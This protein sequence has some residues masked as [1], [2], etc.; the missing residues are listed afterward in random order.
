MNK[1]SR[2]RFLLTFGLIFL[3]GFYWSY[4]QTPNAWI[5]EMHYDNHGGDEDEMIEVV[6]EE[7][8]NWDLSLLRVDFYNGNGGSSYK[9]NTIDSYNVGEEHGSFS[10][11]SCLISG[12][13]NGAPDG[14]ALSYDGTVI[15]FLSYEGVFTATDGPASGQTSTD[16]GVFEDGSDSL[17]ESLQLAGTGYIYS[18]FAWQESSKSTLGKINIAQI[19]G[20]DTIPPVALWNPVNGATDVSITTNLVISFDE[21][22]RDITTDAFFDNT[23]IDAL[24]TFNQT[25]E[26][27]ESVS[28][29]ATIENNQVITITPDAELLNSQL[30]FIAVGEVEDTSDNAS[31]TE[32]ITFTTIAPKDEP[33]NHVT[34]FVAT[35][36]THNAIKLHWQDAAAGSQLPDGYL[37]KA[38]NT[39]I[40][41][42]SDAVDPFEDENLSDG[43]A[44]V[45]VPHG[46]DTT[47]IFE[48]LAPEM[49]YKFKI[50][51]YTN[52]GLTIDFKLDGEV[53]EVN[54]STKNTELF[55]S[56]YIKGSSNN[57]ALEIYNGTGVDVDLSD[58]ILR[59]YFNGSN[60]SGSSIEL[61]GTLAHGDVYV[62]SNG[63]ADDSTIIAETD[64]TSGVTNFNGDD[65]IEL[66]KK[67][68]SIDIIGVTGNDPGTSWE[69]AGIS[70]ATSDHTLIRKSAKAYGNTDWPVSAGTAKENSE[71]IVMPLDYTKNLGDYRAINSDTTLAD[72]TINGKTI[73]GFEP[74]KFTYTVELPFGTMD[75]PTVSAT[76]ND[77]YATVEI[78]QAQNLTGTES[79]RT[80]IV[81]VTADNLCTQDYIVVFSIAKNTANDITGFVFE[82]FEPN[83]IGEIN[84]KDYTVNIEVPYGINVTHLTPTIDIS[85]SATIS[86]QSGVA[87]NFTNPVIYTVTAA[88]SSEQDWIVTVNEGLNTENDILTFVFEDLNP[89]VEGLIDNEQSNVTLTVPYG[90]KVTSLKPTIHISPEAVVSP[91]SGVEQDFT[92][93][94]HYTI[95]AE[96]SSEQIWEVS[97]N[98]ADPSND[99]NLAD[100]KVD[101]FS[102]VDFSETTYNYSIELPYNST[103]TPIITVKK[104]DINAHAVV[105]NAKDVTSETEADRTTTV[106]VTAEDGSTT[107]KY[108]ILFNVSDA[109]SDASLSDLRINGTTKEGFSGLVLEYYDTIDVRPAV[110][111]IVSAKANVSD[112]NINVVNAVNLYGTEEERTTTITVTAED[113]I[114]QKIYTVKFYVKS[115]DATVK[116]LIIDG[117][118]VDSFEPA[119]LQYNIL[120]P[121]GT[122]NAP[123]V[124]AVANNDKALVDISQATESGGDEAVKT[125]F[126]KVTA[127]DEITTLTYQIIFTVADKKDL[128]FSEYIEGESYN[129][130]IELYN[131][132][133]HD[134]DLAPYTVKLASNGEG[135]GLTYNLSDTLASKRAYVIGNSGAS[136]EILA[137]ADTTSGVVNFNGNDALGLFKNDTLIDRIGISTEDKIWDVA[138]VTEATINNTLLRKYSIN[139]GCVNWITSAGTDS[140]NSEWIVWKQDSISNLGI[141]TTANNDATLSE[142]TINGLIVEGFSPF[143][144]QYEVELPFGSVNLPLID[145]ITTDTNATAIIKQIINLDYE[146]EQLAVVKVTAENGFASETY[147]IAFSIAKPS[148]DAFIFSEKYVVEN[149]ENVIS[150]IPFGTLLD[151]LKNNITPSANASFKVYESDGET[152]ATDL[153]SG[154]KVV[155]VAEDKIT[156]NI[157]TISINEPNNEATLSSEDFLIDNI[158]YTITRVPLGTKLTDFENRLITASG[159]SFE[160]FEADGITVADDLK[161][162]Y[163]VI[164][165]AQDEVTINFYTVTVNES[166]R[167]LFFSEYIEGTSDNKALEIYNPTFKTVDLS[168]YFLKGTANAATDW[169][170]NYQFP[171]GASIAS[172]QVYV[173]VNS[174]AHQSMLDSADWVV[175]GLCTGFN[176]N[177]TRGLFK[178]IEEDTTLI[179]VIGNFDNPEGVGYNV[180]GIEDALSDHTLI[181]KSSITVGNKNWISSAG[182]S[183]DSSEWLVFEKDFLDNLGVH[184]IRLSSEAEIIEFTFGQAVAY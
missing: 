108:T 118:L 114:N 44:I 67:D 66:V 74:G 72:L 18:D 8:G 178:I 116:E 130:A 158:D 126:I 127:E 3:T 136:A 34:D 113:N 69:V 144:Y 146:N 128:F 22:I 29:D 78:T 68:V 2:I 179:D 151:T 100:I 115:C 83:I 90:T 1:H 98:V 99:A 7:A 38:S 35:A 157:Y 110:V 91:K 71:W 76:A 125:A 65:V 53:P 50:W 42:P 152:I 15:Q 41:P 54:E 85:D 12:I 62:I 39:S 31:N 124:E 168:N 40:I 155:V 109:E 129:K 47:Y 49:S 61:S 5:N 11:F 153:M 25:D 81:T 156:T 59:L 169:E 174:N 28:F 20:T 75:I 138:G 14:V 26:H 52:E 180:A 161:T 122:A 120:L 181:R 80:A 21:P 58:Y 175:N 123:L 87:Q 23:T 48:G 73:T 164:V 64:T 142:L 172:E 32:Y 4:G 13:Q 104:S 106:T 165:T 159:A 132:C 140:V 27:G 43:D 176:G 93:P 111:P 150:E 89:V 139:K 117:S 96:D 183:V 82:N 94:V 30:Y 105:T 79:Q 134:V 9:N 177:D 143:K 77:N 121:N 162:G 55:I 102:M 92:N 112:A 24:I 95:L 63:S 147:I 51:P 135:W 163:K 171:D 88:D 145:A 141:F 131:P 17:G 10:I 103:Q 60:T 119:V 70:S 101:G 45:K 33:E 173:I 97:V 160:T 133:A 36:L 137:K 19:F 57:K 167:E 86:P 16:I 148:S 166:L 182:T 154:Y 107:Q 170:Y 46:G 84:K 37:I 56:E 184:P 6:V 149:Q